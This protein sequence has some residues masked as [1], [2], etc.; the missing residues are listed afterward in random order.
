[1]GSRNQGTSDFILGLLKCKPGLAQFASTADS[2]KSPGDSPCAGQG[3]GSDS[4]G[5]PL[6][7]GPQRQTLHTGLLLM[8][9][10]LG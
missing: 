1:M 5:L 2:Q 8:S 9:L 3:Q 7:S 4:P 6:P 10:Y